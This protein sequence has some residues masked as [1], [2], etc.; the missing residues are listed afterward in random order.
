VISVSHL[1]SVAARACSKA[2]AV[3]IL[4]IH[5]TVGVAATAHAAVTVTATWNANAEPDIAGYMLSYGTSSGSYASTIDVGKVTNYALQLAGGQTYYFVVRAYNT[6]GRISPYSVEVPFIVPDSPTP[7]LVSVSPS[8]GE[9]GT[10]VTISG[11]SFG[12]SQASSTVTFNGTSATPSTWSATSV[13]VPVPTGATTGNVVVSVAGLVSNGMQF[14]VV[15][16]TPLNTT[17]N[18]SWNANPETN[19][20]GYK[21]SYGSSSGS[22]TSTM[23]VGNVT[24]AVVQ[25]VAGQTYYF[26]VQAYNTAGQLSPYSTEVPFPLPTPPAAPPPTPTLTALSPAS[27]PVGTPITITGLNFGSTPG[28]SSVTFNGT[29]ATPATWSATAIAVP[30]PTGATSGNVVVTV[31]GVPSNALPY[32]VTAPTLP[33]PTL[34]ALSPPSGRIGTIVT[35]TGTNFGATASGN[36]VTFN[37]KIATPVSWSNTSLVVPVPNGA[38]TGGVLVV[39]GGKSSN[40][41]PFVVTRSRNDSLRA[42]DYDG[43]G[44]SDPA[45]FVPATGTWAILLSGTNYSTGLTAWLGT[46]TDVPV[47][48]DYDGDG[49][50]DIAV[51]RPADGAWQILKSSASYESG[52]TYTW[53]ADGDIPVPGD[54][55]GDGTTDFAVYRPS[56]GEWL[57]TLSATKTTMTLVL[58]ATGDVPVTGDFDGDG[59]TDLGVVTPSNGLCSILMSSTNYAMTR[60][61]LDAGAV[62]M[63]PGDDDGDGTIDLAMYAPSTGSWSLWSSVAGT[64]SVATVTLGSGDDIPVPGDYDGDGRTD[65]A[66]YRA[67]TGLWTIIGSGDASVFRFAWGDAGAVPLPRRP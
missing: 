40:V 23:D 35:I 55:D 8:S 66:V 39:V 18:A 62:P 17:V 4:A 14:T 61:V 29:L 6:S 2:R 38:R 49:Q 32:S 13:G 50:T 48:G 42:S 59:R 58:G 11:T 56:T 5:L 1:Q 57:L 33:S 63:A 34:T 9:I 7:T 67:S 16:V 20:A 43:D 19:I 15:A 52:V 30:V 45:T 64:P 46:S 28:A 22:Y 24:N 12:A 36:T 41:L 54:Y 3:L 10:V 47:P 27:G 51:Y 21:L 25:I 44:R 53:G 37:G 31:G 60:L 26:A 65:V